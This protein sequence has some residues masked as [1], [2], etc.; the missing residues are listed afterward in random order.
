MKRK[1][2]MYTMLS[3]VE[4]NIIYIYVFFCIYYLPKHQLNDDF[5]KKLFE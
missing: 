5:L 2:K 1:N 4:L 3:L